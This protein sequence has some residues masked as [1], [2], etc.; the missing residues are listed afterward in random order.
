M[1]TKKKMSVTI[2]AEI[3]ED[4]EKAAETCNM[5]KSQLAQEA[6]RLWL[7]KKTEESMAAGYVDMAK[8][9]REFADTALDAQKEIL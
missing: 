6:F 2:D 3:F 8:E 4:I 9:D 1:R 7:K 5:A